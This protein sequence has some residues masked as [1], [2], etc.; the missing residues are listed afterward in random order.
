MSDGYWFRSKVDLFSN[1]IEPAAWHKVRAS[2]AELRAF[3]RQDSHLP[4][5]V[6][7]KL[8]ELINATQRTQ[9]FKPVSQ[10][11]LRACVRRDGELRGNPLIL[12]RDR[13]SQASP[14]PIQHDI[15]CTSDALWRHASDLRSDD[16]VGCRG[17]KYHQ[18][19]PSHIPTD[20]TAHRQVPPP[21]HAHLGP[22]TAPEAF[23]GNVYGGHAQPACRQ[24]TGGKCFNTGPVAETLVVDKIAQWRRRK[25]TSTCHK[26]ACEVVKAH[27]LVAFMLMQQVQ[28]SNGRERFFDL[29]GLSEFVMGLSYQDFGTG[30][31]LADSPDDVWEWTPRKSCQSRELTVVKGIANGAG[32]RSGGLTFL[33]IFRPVCAMDLVVANSS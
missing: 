19:N 12:P 5:V 31:P 3:R 20:V 9:L 23:S 33:P 27:Q 14:L 29:S 32:Y 1:A 2:V 6:S 13:G 8:R 18:A 26:T 22:N 17:W 11:D 28:E 7:R 4:R 16:H 25:G 10:A 21:C 15:P 30:F 24:Q